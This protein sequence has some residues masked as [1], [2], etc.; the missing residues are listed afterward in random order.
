[1]RTLFC[2][3][4]NTI[5]HTIG[6]DYASARPIPEAIM[7]INESYEAGNTVV[8][9]TSRGS[10]K[11]GLPKDD[12]HILTKQQLAMWGCYYHELR[13]DKPLYDLLI[14]D[15]AQNAT[16]LTDRTIV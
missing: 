12:I 14:D 1:M 2:D 3:I 5:C 15:K 16:I 4:D 9:W 11:T 13:F 6:T 8:Y 7:K 10:L